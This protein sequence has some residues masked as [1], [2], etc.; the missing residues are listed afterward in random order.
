MEKAAA[1]A[2]L[3]SECGS[4]RG[5]CVTAC[6]LATAYESRL[7][8][9]PSGPSSIQLN[10]HVLTTHIITFEYHYFYIGVKNATFQVDFKLDDNLLVTHFAAY[11]PHQHEKTKCAVAI[12]ML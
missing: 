6:G 4:V 11:F 9:L 7:G 3:T 10:S 12:L 2:L 8:S 5:C 1:V